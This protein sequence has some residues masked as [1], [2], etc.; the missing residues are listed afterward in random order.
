M[1]QNDQIGKSF[2]ESHNIA[3]NDEFVAD[4]SFHV[5]IIV[6]RCRFNRSKKMTARFEYLPATYVR[7]SKSQFRNFHS[8]CTQ[9]KKIGGTKE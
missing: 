7:S 1:L 6:S 4:I 5:E 2:K 8:T 9:Q 3:F